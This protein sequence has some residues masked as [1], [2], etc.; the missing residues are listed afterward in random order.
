[1]LIMTYTIDPITGRNIEKPE[2]HPCIHVADEF[3]DLTVY[4]ESEQTKQQFMDVQVEHPESEMR[5]T[6]D[7]PTDEIID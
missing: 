1:M 7:N 4:F 5:H 3:H 2:G 6:L